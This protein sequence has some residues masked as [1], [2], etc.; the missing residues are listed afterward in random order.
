[1]KSEDIIGYLSILLIVF[2]GVCLF[3]LSKSE[4]YKDLS[5]M[6]L[7]Q[8]ATQKT[9]CEASIP[10]DQVCKARITWDI[11]PAK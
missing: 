9:Q 6:T 7:D 4:T 11:V 2:I 3:L 5:G 8:F 1:M 10:R